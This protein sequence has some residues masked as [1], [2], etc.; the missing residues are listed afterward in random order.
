[1]LVISS[2]SLLAIL[3]L[4]ELLSSVDRTS[5]IANFLYLP[6]IP[7]IVLFG[8]SAYETI[9]KLPSITG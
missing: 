7:L 9:I 8:I 5:R 3:T 6:V 1:M 4:K 2:V